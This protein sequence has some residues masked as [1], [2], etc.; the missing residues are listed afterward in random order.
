M[1]MC[2]VKGTNGVITI[3]YWHIGLINYYNDNW[4]LLLVLII[5][6]FYGNK[7]F[8]AFRILLKCL[9]EKS[10]TN[11]DPVCN[12]VKHGFLLA[13]VNKECTMREGW[14]WTEVE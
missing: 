9:K 2:K 10:R 14:S 6:I 8:S 4:K 1:K 11:N 13:A 7:P 5:V 3:S 12:P